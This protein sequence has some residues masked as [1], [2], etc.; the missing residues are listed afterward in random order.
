MDH[1]EKGRKYHYFQCAAKKCKLNGGVKRYQT[2]KDKSATS[3]LKAHTIKC[4]GQDAVDAT[5]KKNG[6]KDH[7]PDQS[8]FS[9]F[10]RIGQKPVKFS[11]RSHT[12][13]ETR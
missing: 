1:D 2:T 9:I 6:S 5:L 11:H 3:N 4:H 7:A 10:A 8:I 12:S 13:V